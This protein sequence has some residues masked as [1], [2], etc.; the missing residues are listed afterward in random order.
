MKLVCISDMHGTLDFAVK[1]SDLLIIAGDMCPYSGGGA[2]MGCIQQEIWLRD[3]FG[4][5]LAEQP[6]KEVVAT[7]GNHDWIWELAPMMVP[8]MPANFHCLVDKGI[9]ILGL[10]IYG[11]PQQKV[12]C[13]WAFNRSPAQLMRYYAEIPEGLDILISHAPPFGVMDDV[14][15]KMGPRHEGSPELANRIQRMAQKP[16]IVV[17]GHFHAND[18]LKEYP[19]FPGTVFVNCSVVGENYVRSKDPIYLEFDHE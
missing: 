18:G 2:Q 13:D 8:R 6:V 1:P 5:W 12:F 19:S 4:P 11:T 17:C 3:E 7:P 15:S 14:M 9:E 10:K 16:R